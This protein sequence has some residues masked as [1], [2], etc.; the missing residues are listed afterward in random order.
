MI[1]VKLALVA[2]MMPVFF[3]FVVRSRPRRIALTVEAFRESLP[4]GPAA[5]AAS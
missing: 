2:A 4:K 5:E 1:W 3:A